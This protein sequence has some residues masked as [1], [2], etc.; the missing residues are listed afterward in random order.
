MM[1]Q[2]ATIEREKHGADSVQRLVRA[3][4]PT[5]YCVDGCEKLMQMHFGI[6]RNYKVYVCRCGACYDKQLT[7][8]GL[9]D[10]PDFGDALKM[11]H[12]LKQLV[13]VMFPMRH[14]ENPARTPAL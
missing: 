11:K 2:P 14:D 3:S 7:D 13:E 5:F 12:H 9:A 8:I 1:K 10:D 6:V 4:G